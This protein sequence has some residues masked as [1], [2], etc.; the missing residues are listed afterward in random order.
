MDARSAKHA[1][2]IS[3]QQEKQAA[4]D[5]GGRVQAASGALRLGGGADV[6]L[7]GKVRLECKVTEKSSYTLKLTE[8][9][10]LRKQAI[11]TLELPVLQFAFR[12]PS[13]KLN[14]YAVIPRPPNARNI[15]TEWATI[16][17]QIVIGEVSLERVLGEGHLSIGFSYPGAERG[18]FAMRHF[19]VMR[20]DEF[21]ETM[22]A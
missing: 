16:S 1:K 10:K 6:R 20:W 4:E 18:T 5:L 13:G 7:H 11:K 12:H 14:R 21:V 22:N 9:E 15:A 17:K 19:E 2:R 8:L 3:K